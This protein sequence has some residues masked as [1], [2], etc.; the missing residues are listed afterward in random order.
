MITSISLRLLD[1]DQAFPM[2]DD[3]KLW[4]LEAVGRRT[5]ISGIDPQKLRIFVFHWRLGA[6][7]GAFERGK[8]GFL[9]HI[10]RRRAT[11]YFP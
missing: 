11:F 3:G 5:R 1:T 10:Y 6:R 8:F 2:A 4:C 7:V 9:S